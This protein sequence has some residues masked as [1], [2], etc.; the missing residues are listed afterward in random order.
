MSTS[1]FVLLISKK[2][3][4]PHHFKLLPLMDHISLY[5]PLPF[6]KS[7]L[8]FEWGTLPLGL[9][10]RISRNGKVSSLSFTA[11]IKGH[12]LGVEKGGREI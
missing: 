1:F 8:G 3:S 5:P 9:I 10:C 11:I 6:S 2:I 12:P 4:F 7:S